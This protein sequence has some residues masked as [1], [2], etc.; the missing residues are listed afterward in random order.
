MFGDG[1][2]GADG[3]GS[4]TRAE[5]SKATLQEEDDLA[6]TCSLSSAEISINATEVR[7]RIVDREKKGQ[8]TYQAWAS[9][10]NTAVQR[11]LRLAA[12][13]NLLYQL[14]STLIIS[15]MPLAQLGI[16]VMSPPSPALAPAVAA[17]ACLTYGVGV[18]SDIMENKRKAGEY[19]LREKRWSILSC[20]PIQPD[21]LAM[22]ALHTTLP[23]IRS[24]P[25]RSRMS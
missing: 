15:L 18:I 1:T 5:R 9:E 17:G 25:A 14:D 2:A 13:K 7:S 22:A 11:G 16:A 12:R 21:R 8:E 3:A 6:P 10:L 20:G 24:K 19:H 23:I 4:A